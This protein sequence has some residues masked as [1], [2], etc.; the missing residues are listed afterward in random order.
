MECWAA[1]VDNER[2]DSSAALVALYKTGQLVAS[3]AIPGV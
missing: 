3:L 2:M 1:D